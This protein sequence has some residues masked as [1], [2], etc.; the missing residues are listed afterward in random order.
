MRKLTGKQARYIRGLGH[1]IEPTIMV[2]KDG[3]TENLLQ[4]LDDNLSAHELVKVKIQRTC[5]LER[6]EAA[7]VL[8][9]KSDAA[10]AQVL[11]NTILLYRPSEE[12]RIELPR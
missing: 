10:V 12:Q 3:V 4:S 5:L 9:E 2:G 6:K 8:A 11:G 1:H 7:E